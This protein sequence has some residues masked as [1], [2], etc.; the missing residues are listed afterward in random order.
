[1]RV[2]R[3]PDSTAKP[4]AVLILKI[5]P[6]DSGCCVWLKKR[7]HGTINS[8][9][10]IGRASAVSISFRA[11]TVQEEQGSRQIRPSAFEMCSALLIS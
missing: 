1:M 11:L 3:I 6:R 2:S 9:S 5:I 10:I 4:F 7:H 8:E